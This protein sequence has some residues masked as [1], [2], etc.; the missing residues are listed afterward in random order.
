MPSISDVLVKRGMNGDLVKCGA[1]YA[2]AVIP[3]IMKVKTMGD[4]LASDYEILEGKP[5]TAYIIHGFMLHIFGNA[6]TLAQ[7]LSI[8]ITEFYSCEFH[9]L[10]G[11]NIAPSVV[12]NDRIALSGLNVMTYPDTPVIIKGDGVNVPAWRSATV[13]YTE[14]QI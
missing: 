9:N 1:Q 10:D 11:P 7:A 8:N 13:Y 12:A 3:P 14:V 2:Q 5:N 4:A 6:G